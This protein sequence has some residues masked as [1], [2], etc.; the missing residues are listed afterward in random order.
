MSGGSPELDQPVELV[1]WVH[2]RDDINLSDLIIQLSGYFVINLS[3][4]HCLKSFI[5]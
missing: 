1:L 3:V 2:S 4:M 5:F